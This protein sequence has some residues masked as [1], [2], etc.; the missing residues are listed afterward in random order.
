MT[1]PHD[2]QLHS[3]LKPILDPKPPPPL[4]FFL[5]SWIEF[6]YLITS[7]ER[8]R[9]AK[10][11]I[12]QESVR[13]SY[14]M[15]ILSSGISNPTLTSSITS[16]VSRSTYMVHWNRRG[17]GKPPTEAQTRDDLKWWV[18]R[19]GGRGGTPVEKEITIINPGFYRL[20]FPGD[21]SVSQSLNHWSVTR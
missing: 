4:F 2:H 3:W 17:R 16:H 11:K 19:V 14:A 8:A 5:K 6:N 9:L 13:K 20:R 21:L 15:D 7:I 10:L 12:T 1:G 18:D